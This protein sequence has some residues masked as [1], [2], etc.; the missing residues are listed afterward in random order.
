[1]GGGVLVISKSQPQTVTQKTVGVTTG[2][3]KPAT[4]LGLKGSSSHLDIKVPDKLLF[5]NTLFSILDLSWV[6]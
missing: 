3:S 1:M 4:W 2:D 6:W 5:P